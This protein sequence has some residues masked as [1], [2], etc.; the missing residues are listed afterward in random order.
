MKNKSGKSN[1][2]N[3]VENAF[4]SSAESTSTVVP[5]KKHHKKPKKQYL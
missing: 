1:A 2:T 5:N 4:S 3:K